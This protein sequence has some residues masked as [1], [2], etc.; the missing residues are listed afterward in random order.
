METN[1]ANGWKTVPEE[2]VDYVKEYMTGRGYGGD[3]ERV[4]K[5]S[6][7]YAKTVELVGD[8]R[9]VWIFDIDDTLLS[10]LPYYANH[11][12]GYECHGLL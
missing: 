3:L 2:C 7:D 10:N 9:D 5:E 6:E 8:G 1:S 11:G 4:S 12:Y